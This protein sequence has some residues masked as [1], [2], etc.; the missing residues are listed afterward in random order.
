MTDDVLK[1]VVGTLAL[2]IDY[3]S[4]GQTFPGVKLSLL[5]YES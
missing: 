1:S 5:T 2:S 4:S 3:M